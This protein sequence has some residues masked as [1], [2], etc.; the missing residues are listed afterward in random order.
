MK[1]PHKFGATRTQCQSGHSHPSKAEAYRCD[2]LHILQRAGQI[3]G[4]EREP[5]FPIAINGVKI[6]TYKADFAYWDDGTRVI[7]DVKGHATPIYKL[8]KKLVEA[9][10]PGVKIVEV[11]R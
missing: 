6:C 7:E 4:L 11:R 3:C 5:S 2:Q 9:S 8:K 10:Y 1:R